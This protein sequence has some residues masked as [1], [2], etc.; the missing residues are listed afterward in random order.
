MYSEILQFLEGKEVEVWKMGFR[1]EVPVARRQIGKG[2]LE[3]DNY[4]SHK[5]GWKIN[6]YS[7]IT[8]FFTLSTIWKIEILD[9]VVRIFLK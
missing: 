5:Y 1:E 9:E 7:S 2:I 4:Y 8:Q 3:N 6:N